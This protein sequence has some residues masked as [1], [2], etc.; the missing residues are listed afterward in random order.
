MLKIRRV[1]IDTYHEDVA[2]LSRSCEEYRPEE[3]QALKKI[4]ISHDGGRLLATLV[5]AD[6]SSTSTAGS[7]PS[8]TG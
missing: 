4:E 6:S 1:P 8:P 3:Y 7:I 5:I 2:L